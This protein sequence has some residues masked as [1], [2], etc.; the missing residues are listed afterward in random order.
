MNN[1]KYITHDPKGKLPKIFLSLE[2]EN[3]KFSGKVELDE[4][5]VVA[6][7]VRGKRVRGEAGKRNEELLFLAF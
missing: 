2:K 5:Y 4:S 6:K 7:R 3:E 1:Y